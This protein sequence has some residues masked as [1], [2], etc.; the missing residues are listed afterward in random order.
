MNKQDPIEKLF[1]RLKGELDIHEPVTDHQTKFLKK[2]QQ[3]NV[4]ELKPQKPRWIKPLSIAA[5]IAIL[6]GA[7]LFAPRPIKEADLASVSPQMQETQSFFTSAIETQL[8]EINAISSSETKELVK[9][10]MIQLEKLESDYQTLKKDLVESGND[11]RVIS[12]MIKNF[13]KRANLLEEVL[14][15]MNTINK[16]NVTDH[17]NTIL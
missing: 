14:E 1:D 2:L 15:K 4:V 7:V 12:A 10:A 6:I 13:Q 17:E 9:D 11:K 3:R 16:F 5:T 8:E